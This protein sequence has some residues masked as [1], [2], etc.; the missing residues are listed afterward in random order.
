MNFHI[1]CGT[2]QSRL[3]KKSIR[4]YR[5]SAHLVRTATN[6]VFVGDLICSEAWLKLVQEFIHRNI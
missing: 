6:S 1:K 5:G 4:G 2:E 3:L